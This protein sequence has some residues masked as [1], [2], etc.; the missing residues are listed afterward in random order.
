MH[1]GINSTRRMVVWYCTWYIPMNWDIRM[2]NGAI[3]PTLELHARISKESIAVHLS[4]MRDQGFVP[5]PSPCCS[6]WVRI[7]GAFG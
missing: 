5:S 1:T 3:P 6:G 2:N 4:L 7:I